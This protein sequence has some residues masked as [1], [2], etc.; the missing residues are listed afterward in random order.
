[1]WKANAKSDRQVMLNERSTSEWGRISKRVD[2]AEAM[3]DDEVAWRCRSS[4]EI[5]RDIE[6]ELRSIDQSER[7]KKRFANNIEH[8]SDGLSK[9]LL[10]N[11]VFK[12]CKYSHQ[13]HDGAVLEV[14][15]RYRNEP[16]F[17]EKIENKYSSE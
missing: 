16:K 2:G 13:A 8:M 3:D 5:D 9:L 4:A 6:Q 7:D 11:D 1:M 10:S 15:N 12:Y 17:R 14:K